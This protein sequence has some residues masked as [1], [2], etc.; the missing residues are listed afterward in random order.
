[1]RRYRIIYRDN[2]ALPYSDKLYEMGE[3]K[4][5][6]KEVQ[7]IEIGRYNK[8]ID[9]LAK[10]EKALNLLNFDK[11]MKPDRINMDQLTQ[12]LEPLHLIPVVIGDELLIDNLITKDRHPAS[13]LQ[14][15]CYINLTRELFTLE[16]VKRTWSFYDHYDWEAIDD[17]PETALPEIRKH[18]LFGRYVKKGTVA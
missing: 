11:E 10:T 1:M 13:K 8:I 9:D 17:E 5:A 7:Q 16:K 18:G 12:I 15:Q 3:L 14:V 6:E 2:S 4:K